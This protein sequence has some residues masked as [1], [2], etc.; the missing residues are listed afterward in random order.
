MRLLSISLLLSAILFIQCRDL[1]DL[2]FLYSLIAIIPVTIYTYRAKWRYKVAVLFCCYL[3]MGFLWCLF[4]ASYNYFSTSELLSGIEGKEVIVSGYIDSIPVSLSRGSRFVFRV[5]E[6]MHGNERQPYHAR[7]LLSWY[8]RAQQVQA[9]ED[10]QLTVKLKRPHGFMNPGGFDYEAWLFQNGIVATGYVRDKAGSPGAVRIQRTEPGISWPGINSIRQKLFF[11]IS[12][13]LESSP[14]T[15]LIT[16]LA[17]G[18]RQ[19]ILPQQWEVLRNTGTSHLV[20]ISGLHIGLIAGLAFFL[21][22]RVC[23]FASGIFTS[24]ALSRLCLVLPANKIAAMISVIAAIIYAA[25]AGFSI[26]TQRALVMVGVVMINIIFNRQNS[27]SSILA[28]AIFVI[29]LIDPFAVMDVAFWLSFCAVSTILF[30]MS[31]RL[32]CH[33]LWWK[34]GRVQLIVFI[35]LIPVMLVVFQQL[36]LVSPVAN[37]VAVPW[38]SFIT[39]PLTLAGSLSLYAGFGS[40][41]ITW[42]AGSLDLLW[43]FLQFTLKFPLFQWQQHVPVV[44]TVI[45]AVV[46]VFILLLPRGVPAKWLVIFMLFPL[47]LIKPEGPQNSDVLFTLLDV[48]QGLAAVVQTQHHVLV[49]DTG[50]QYSEKFNAGESIITPFL[51]SRGVNKIDSLIVSHA[52]NDHSGGLSAIIEN[53]A[54]SRILTGEVREI[55]RFDGVRHAEPC[56]DNQSWSWDGVKFAM[57][58]PP[59]VN[60][61]LRVTGN[62][63]SCVLKITSPYGSILLTG[64]IE[65]AAEN[66]LHKEINLQNKVLR[67]DILV[68][69]HHGSKTSSTAGFVADVNAKYALIPVGYRNRFGLPEGT[70]MHRYRLSGAQILD[71]ASNGAIEFRLQR[72]N[73]EMRYSTVRRENRRFYHQ[74]NKRFD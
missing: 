71:T 24:G 8:N 48:G 15:G 50:P 29:L 74:R 62:N 58:Y 72:T 22:I 30:A 28:V 2:R 17:I 32:S 4:Y 40:E 68:V 73:S 6:V 12:G 20:A 31:N 35:G 56:N 53:F 69:P 27:P 38:V 46:A 66:Y 36:S 64:D 34:W 54:I 42:A 26:P 13:S 41:L 10:W 52:D 37:I 47:V 7:V 59:E 39:V 23:R 70:V 1:P 14:F 67:S 51:K 11:L 21:T 45:F 9:G 61:T 49:Y 16:A 25:M 18:E 44:W 55:N 5:R 65:L 43:Q 19:H 3:T 33:T 57:M 63:A 60:E